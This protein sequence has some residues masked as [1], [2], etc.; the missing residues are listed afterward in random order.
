VLEHQP[1]VNAFLRGVW[2]ALDPGGVLAITVPPAKAKIV[3]GHLSLW[4]AGLL[5]YHLV[6]AGFDCRHARVK[7]YRYNISVIVQKEG[8]VREVD[9][10]S[11]K[12]DKG[13][14]KALKEYFPPGLK[15][16]GDSFDGDIEELNWE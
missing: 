5:L 4:N 7:R 15:W 6:L 12:W 16:N 14:L 10:R 1:D 9:P 8:L 2:E 11:L 3:G 13:D